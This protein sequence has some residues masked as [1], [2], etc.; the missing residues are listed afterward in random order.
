M[1]VTET[2]DPELHV[3]PVVDF[4]V[5]GID[6]DTLRADGIGA[7]DQLLGCCGVLHRG[8]DLVGNEINEGV[9]GFLGDQ[10]VRKGAADGEP[11]L[12]PAVFIDA[13]AFFLRRLHGQRFGRDGG[14][15][16]D[17]V[18]AS[19]LAVGFAVGEPVLADVWIGGA[20]V[21]GDREARRALEDVQAADIGRDLCDR[22]HG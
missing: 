14:Y 9:V 17:R 22:L 15:N 10:H 6:A 4:E 8:A 3:W 2:G 5:P 19:G 16:A 20:V 1:G 11:A 12:G 21:G 13:I 7:W 18:F